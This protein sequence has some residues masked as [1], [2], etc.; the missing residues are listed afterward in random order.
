MIIEFTGVPCCGKSAVSHELAKLLR[1]HGYSVCEKQYEVS[2]NTNSAVRAFKKL[3]S[4]FG[5]CLKHPKKALSDYRFIGSKRLWL[6]DMYMR[7]HKCKQDVCILEQGYLQLVG[8]FFDGQKP[9]AEKM[10]ILLNRVVPENEIV[11]VFVAASQETVLERANARQDK[12][13][14]MQA[15][16]PEK[17]LEQVFATVEMLGQVWRANRGEAGAITVWNEQGHTPRESAI[18][19]FDFM[20]QKGFL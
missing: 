10:K 4:C 6:N 19:I 16:Q 7:S 5:Y 14:F 8:S 18:T 11:Q 12:P 15:E 13:F 3:L 9:D 1:D 20:K 2:H 17:A